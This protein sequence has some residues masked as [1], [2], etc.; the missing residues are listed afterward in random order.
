L[1]SDRPGAEGHRCEDA[2]DV[3]VGGW[4][5]VGWP[6]CGAPPVALVVE[7]AFEAE[8]AARVAEF[9]AVVVAVLAATCIVRGVWSGGREQEGVRCFMHERRE[10]LGWCFEEVRT[11]GDLVSLAGQRCFP[12]PGGEVAA[13]TRLSSCRNRKENARR[14]PLINASQEL[15]GT[16]QARRNARP[17]LID[18]NGL[19]QSL[20]Y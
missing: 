2:E 18:R 5:A 20:V 7:V 15:P 9:L 17:T 8:L 14:N 6:L 4:G 13:F 16:L 19:H 1:S 12:F 3:M 11:D 10:K